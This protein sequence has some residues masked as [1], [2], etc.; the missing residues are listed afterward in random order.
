MQEVN[1][2][3][4]INGCTCHIVY[5]T[6]KK[7]AEMFILES[8]FMLRICLLI[9]SVDLT[10]RNVELDEFCYFCGQVYR[11]IIRHVITRR[12][13]LKAAVTRTLQLYQ[14]LQ[15][16]FLSQEVRPEVFLFFCQYTLQSFVNFNK[17][18]QWEGPWLSGLHDRIQQFLKIFAFKF[19]QIGFVAGGDMFSDA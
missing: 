8:G 9:Y 16:Y 1:N 12:L 10:K 6:A 14:P 17:Y 18:P 19:L 3:I 7:G 13:S 4:Y 2:S 5:N 15:S 11:R